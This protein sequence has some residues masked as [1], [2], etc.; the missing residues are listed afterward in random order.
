VCPKATFRGAVVALAVLLLASASH[1]ALAQDGRADWRHIGNSAIDLALP[2]AATGPVDRV[3]YSPDGAVLFARTRSGRTFQTTDFEKWIQTGPSIVPPA[4]SDPAAANSPEPGARARL[5]GARMYSFARNAFRSDD[6][7]ASWLNLTAYKGSSILG[8]PLADF[9]VSPSNP[10]EISAANAAGVW[11]SVD[12]GL[13]WMGLNASLPNLPVRRLF[14]IPDGTRGVRI[15]LALD[16]APEL[17][18]SPGEK[19]AW[20]VGDSAESDRDNQLKQLASQAL[21]AR[22]TAVASSG[23]AVYAGSADGRLWVSLD[24]GATWSANWATYQSGPVEAFFVDP[25]DT[26]GAVAVF[27]AH[28]QPLSP[29]VQPVH[30]MRTMNAGVFWDSTTGN[31]PDVAV[32]GVT[33][34]QASHA[35]YVATDTG[36]FYSTLDG[37]GRPGAWSLVGEGLPN[38]SA[39]DVRLDAAGNQLYVALDGYGVYAAVAPHRFRDP[40]VVNAADYSGRA[41]AP[42]SLLS[43]LGARVTSARAG[44]TSAPVLATDASGT[45]IQVPFDAQGQSLSLALDSSRGRVLTGF[46]LRNVSP[47][48]FIDPD[49]TPMLLDGD[50]GVMLDASNPARSGS[51]I[52]ILATGLGRVDPDWPTGTPGPAADAPRVVAPMRAYLDQTPI[53]VSRAVLAPYVGFYLIEIQLPRIVNAGPAEL[54]IEAEGQPSNRVRLY[55][56]P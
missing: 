52:Q 45:Q 26:R 47:A 12:A 13:T 15:G 44:D 25:K 16:G 4:D 29:G 56:Q 3:W 8:S 1:V 53:D 36:V 42:G 2:S 48:I 34:D 20:R 27:G 39:M 6:N 32:H 40:R 24:K 17:E 41:A 14:G 22:I 30:V 19:M 31:L 7:G 28:P 46:P 37:T 9:A 23:D 55:I 10:D 50:S 49:G 21:S 5:S 18:W 43:V 54:Y 11:R 51:R 33:A 38:A 35:I